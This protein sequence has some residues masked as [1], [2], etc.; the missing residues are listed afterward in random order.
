MSQSSILITSPTGLLTAS[1]WRNRHYRFETEICKR[2]YESMIDLASF[3]SRVR[4]NGLTPWGWFEII[5]FQH[6]FPFSQLSV[7]S[8]M[9]VEGKLISTSFRCVC[10]FGVCV[11]VC[12][13]MCVCETHTSLACLSCS[14]AL[15]IQTLVWCRPEAHSNSSTEMLNVYFKD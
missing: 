13:C 9:K 11:S 3:Q 7:N 8:C 5:L 12:V 4:K 1:N 14:L 15:H 2:G 10:V 6:F